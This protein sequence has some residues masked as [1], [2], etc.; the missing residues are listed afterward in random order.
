METGEL[1]LER[2]LAG[3]VA[4]SGVDEVVEEI[5]MSWISFLSLNTVVAKRHAPYS[6]T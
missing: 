3:D 2:A 1:E 6:L 4:N 5:K